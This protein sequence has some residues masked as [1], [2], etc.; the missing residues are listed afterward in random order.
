[1]KQDGASNGLK[2]VDARQK[3]T[4]TQNPTLCTINDTFVM[5]SGG[6]SAEYVPQ[7]SVE[8]YNTVEETSER[9]PDL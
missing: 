6:Y 3:T 9:L 2:V 8:L 7:N 1:M 5:I 4:D